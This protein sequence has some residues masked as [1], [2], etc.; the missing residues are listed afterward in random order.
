MT[1]TDAMSDAAEDACYELYHENSKIGRN[2]RPLPLARSAMR[3]RE[4][5]EEQYPLFAVGEADPA[6]DPIAGLI[7][8][9]AGPLKSGRLTTRQLAALL[10]RSVVGDGKLVEILFHVRGV[11]GLPAGLFRLGAKGEARLMRRG[12][13]GKEL[14]RILLAPELAGTPLQI[15][16]AGGFAGAAALSGE[17]GYRRV[18]LAV[19]A[20]SE[21]IKL[22]ATALG[23]G[24]V[25][26]TEFY[27]REL[28]RLLGLDGIDVGALVLIAVGGA[29]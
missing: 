25:T 2:V 21:T 19:G 3:S 10:P 7:G 18:L 27:D 14:A 1:W 5:I 22:T 8:K 11:D 17:R 29:G 4:Q 24:I 26:T 16:I 23:L 28:D 9:A 15:V 13:F 6:A 20:R 12:D